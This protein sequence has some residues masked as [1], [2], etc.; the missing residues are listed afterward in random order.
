MSNLGIDESSP[1]EAQN[2]K[3]Q[4]LQSPIITNHDHSCTLLHLWEGNW[5]QMGSIPW[6][7]T[8]RVYRG[9]RA[10]RTRLEEVLLST[11]VA[12]SRRSD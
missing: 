4:L 11:H 3:L 12:R 6:T 7:I 9:R 8:S 5:Q 1:T 2:I 10:R